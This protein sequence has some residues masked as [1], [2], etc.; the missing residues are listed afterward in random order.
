MS[1]DLSYG[2]RRRSLP[3]DVRRRPTP[4]SCPGRLGSGIFSLYRQMSSYGDVS[5][6]HHPLVLSPV[7][8]LR[9]IPPNAIRLAH[10]SGRSRR[11]YRFFMSCSRL[12]GRE[13]RCSVRYWRVV[14]MQV[15]GRGKLWK[16]L[17]WP[18][19]SDGG[20]PQRT[21][22]C[23]NN[24][25]SLEEAARALHASASPSTSPRNAQSHDHFSERYEG[26]YRHGVN[27][28]YWP[29]LKKRRLGASVPNLIFDP[30]ASGWMGPVKENLKGKGGVSMI[31]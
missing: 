1:S 19:R 12:R 24:G 16:G 14:L 25:I 8:L 21:G 20:W 11:F 22:T 18:L 28:R 23:F 17:C 7:R 29:V 10:K 6:P 26:R 13:P 30:I 5:E 2:S 4:I 15:S 9:G 27:R 31:L 3:Y